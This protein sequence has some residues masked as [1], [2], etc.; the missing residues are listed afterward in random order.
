[1]VK[2]LITTVL[3]LAFS[4]CFAKPAYVECTI[5]MSEKVEKVSIKFD[6]DNVKITHT[7]SDGKVFNSDGFFSANVI[8]YKHLS[9]Y[10]SMEISQEFQINRSDL[11][12]IY[13]LNLEPID[14]KLLDKIPAS[15]TNYKGQCSLVKIENRQL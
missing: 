15:R 12:L 8:S 3:A 6:E 5:D 1:M 14:K 9:F 4:P 7:W 11:S 13:V 2:L 10:R